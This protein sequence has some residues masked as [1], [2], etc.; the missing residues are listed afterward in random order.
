MHVGGMEPIVIEGECNRA[1]VYAK[2]MD[3]NCK[4]SVLQYL[5][6]PLFADTKVRIMPDVHFG[7]EA[8]V[9]F[10]ATCNE[11]VIPS[12]IGVDIGCGINAYNLGKGNVACDKLDKYIRKHIPVGKM[13]HPSVCESL[14]AAYAYVGDHAMPFAAFGENIATLA[15]K[16]KIPVERVWNALGTLGGGNHFIEIDRDEAQCR[17]LLIHTGSR[18]FGLQ[19]AMYH[20]KL[21][22]KRTSDESNIKFLSGMAAEEY[23]ADMTFAQFYARV[24]RAL[25]AYQIGCDFFKIA[26]D[27]LIAIESV[28]NYIDFEH[29]IIRKG[30]ISAQKGEPLVIPFSMADGAIIGVGKGSGEWNYSAPHGSGRKLSRTQAKELSLDQYRTQMKGVWS[31]CINENTLDESPMA[32]KSSKDILNFVEDTLS[33]T[34]RLRPIYNF[35]ADV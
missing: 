18:N 26:H 32:Y 7:R 30:A 2:A 22:S 28:H 23:I 20:Q 31:S 3:E 24:N 9:G 27:R 6:H 12:L 14:E 13:L 17:W 19:V 11:Y 8:L 34:N 1:I 5:N 25:I 21:A 33:V 4:G 29:K 10:T 15:A 35:K 16:L